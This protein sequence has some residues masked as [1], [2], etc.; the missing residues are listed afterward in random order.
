MSFQGEINNGGMHHLLNSSG[1]F[2][3][4]T[5]DV[6]KRIGAPAAAEILERANSYFG[7][8]GPPTDRETRMAILLA[9]PENIEQQICDLTNDFYNVE[10]DGLSLAD[11]F[12]VYVL[13]QRQT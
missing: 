10:D 6:M 1:D 5:P 8:A 2:A 12:D 7:P 3:Q 11:L 9:L 13:S 4:E